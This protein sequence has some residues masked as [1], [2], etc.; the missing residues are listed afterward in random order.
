MRECWWDEQVEQ[1]EAEEREME[2][3]DG[4]ARE[5]SGYRG[6]PEELLERRVDRAIEE[7]LR[8]K[9]WVTASEVGRFIAESSAGGEARTG[10]EER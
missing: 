8:E 2:E 7:A 4:R 6:A 3:R 9:G 10:E 5:T 1:I